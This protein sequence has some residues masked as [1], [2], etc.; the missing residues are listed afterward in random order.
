M[1]NPDQ[2]IQSDFAVIALLDALGT[3]GLLSRSAPDGLLETWQHLL[4]EL[5]QLLNDVEASEATEDCSFLAFSDTILIT[6][7]P[8]AEANQ[9]SCLSLMHTLLQRFLWPGLMAG[10]YFRGAI[11]VGRFLQSPFRVLGESLEEA[12]EWY[13]QADWMGVMATPSAGHLIEQMVLDGWDMA[14]SLVR[15]DVPLRNKN[16]YDTWAVNWPKYADEEAETVNSSGKATLLRSFRAYSGAISPV[17]VAKY[18]NTL[19]FADKVWDAAP[20]KSQ[21]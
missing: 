18:A 12:A 11:S 17:I 19:A 1:A 21:P 4:T 16:R 8:T 15:H 20:P 2:T 6:I 13:E 9:A 5:E 3:K 10:V 7:I 14:E